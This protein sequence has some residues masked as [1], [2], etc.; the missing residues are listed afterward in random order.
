[1]SST[2]N[3]QKLQL[4]IIELFDNNDNKIIFNKI[5]LKEEHSNWSNN[6]VIQVYVDNI[7]LT[8]TQKRSYKVI[9]KCR[10]GCTS[11]ILLRKYLAKE[12]I[13]CKHCLQNR[14]FDYFSVSNNFG[15][16]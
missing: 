7:K 10:C 1:M 2:I 15:K 5:E 13:V 14:S 9:Y 6:N 8:N 12:H 4:H 16:K 11:K 3:L